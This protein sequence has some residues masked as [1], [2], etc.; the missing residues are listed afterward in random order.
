MHISTADSGPVNR[1]FKPRVLL[2]F[3][4]AVVCAATFLRVSQLTGRL[5]QDLTYDDIGYANDA[6]DRLT[7][8]ARHGLIKFLS[9]L[10]QNPPHSPYST[11]LALC[12][13]L[14]GGV[15]DLAFYAANGLML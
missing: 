15:N 4:L 3:M 6:F 9:D 5:A 14:V 1:F 12:G 13:F 2:A 8:V 7:V 11:I 10:A